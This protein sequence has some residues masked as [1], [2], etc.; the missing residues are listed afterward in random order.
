MNDNVLV[1]IRCPNCSAEGPF[2]IEATAEFGSEAILRSF[3]DMCA[4]VLKETK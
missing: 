4:R 1:G 2:R 3:K